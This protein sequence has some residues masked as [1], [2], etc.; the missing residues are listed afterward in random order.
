M[1][2]LTVTSLRP[3]PNTNEIRKLNFTKNQYCKLAIPAK[4]QANLTTQ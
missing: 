2:S 1:G 4:R 3:A